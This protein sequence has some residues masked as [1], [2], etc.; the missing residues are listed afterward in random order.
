MR[1]WWPVLL[2]LTLLS[3]APAPPPARPT[4]GLPGPLTRDPARP[5]LEPRGDGWEGLAVFNPAVIY[6]GKDYVLLYRA[7]DR[8]GVS[9]LGLARSTDGVTFTRDDR[10]VF[11]PATPEEAGGVEDPRL[12]RVGET[13]HLTYTAFDGRSTA[14]LNMA[15][16]A[17]LKTWTRHGSLFQSGWS[18]AGAMLD[19]PVNGLNFMYFGDKEI[20][21]AT[22]PDRN[23][24]TPEDTPVLRPRPGTWDEGGVEPGPPPILTE[25]GILLIYNGRDRNNVYAVGAALFDRFDPGVLL[26]R[27][28]Q[29]ILT[30]QTAW[31]KTGTVPNVVFA[32]GLVIRGGRMEIYY[33]GGDRVVGRAVV[34]WP[35]RR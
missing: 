34:D 33:G 20:R 14:R 2:C 23:S 10:P 18:K 24:W 28:E 9:R 25:R 19:R 6:D 30:V 11:E 26:A 4:T 17:D 32:E 27:S 15:T 13:Y 35:N 12:V 5:L 3:A 16:S 1:P 22:S 7:Q 8:R 31:E 21:L 29:P